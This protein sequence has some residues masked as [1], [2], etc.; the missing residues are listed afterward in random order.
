MASTNKT[1]HLNLSQWVSED[2]P[3]MDDFNQ[4][5]QKVDSAIYQHT[6]NQ[7]VHLT[8]QQAQWLE[9]PFVVGSYQGNGSIRQAISLGKTPR[10]VVVSI[11]NGAPYEYD[12]NAQYAI[13][14]FAM[15]FDTAS[16]NGIE[17][18]ENGFAVYQSLGAPSV[19]G[20]FVALNQS[21]YTYWYMALL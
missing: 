3:K 8:Q 4:D 10:F 13:Q 17:A 14:R 16:S 12:P 2:C 20:T 5:N 6:S 21:G 18:E 7:S 19:G 11:M 15:L 9:A 1:T